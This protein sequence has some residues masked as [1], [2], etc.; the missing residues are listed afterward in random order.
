MSGI[1]NIPSL[2]VLFA[3]TFAGSLAYAG[4][5]W[6]MIVL[7]AKLG[8]PAMVGQYSFAAAI[9]YPISLIANLQ[10]RVVFVNDHEGRWP[11]RRLLGARYLLAAL[12]WVTL[13]LICLCIRSSGR[14]TAL[15]VLLGTS[16]L[17]DSLSESYY[18]LLQKSERMDRVGRSQMFKNPLCLAIAGITLYFTRDIVFAVGAALLGRLATLIFYDSA[19]ETFRITSASPWG[20][21]AYALSGTF[22]AR[23]RPQWSLRSQLEMIWIALPLGAVYVLSSFNMNI[24]RYVIE[25]YLG[26]HELGI[27]SALSYLPFAAVLFAS[28]LGYVTF[29]RLGRMFFE[30]DVPKF[31]WLL[32]RMVMIAAGLGILGFLVSAAAGK[33]ILRILYRPEYAEHVD[34]LL[35]LVVVSGV[36]CIANCMGVAMTAA[37]QFR[38]QIPLFLVM[39][40]VSALTAFALVPRIGLY[41]AALASLAAV[42]VQGVGGY[43]IVRRALKRRVAS[44]A[45]DGRDSSLVADALVSES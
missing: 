31:K 36:A 38:P 16:M 17:L 30:G 26:P 42:T 27:Y 34:L 44:A 7:F 10:L 40:A 33:P 45:K 18:S 8:N 15:I 41:G 4:A 32:G 20:A 37:S 24:P 22:F 39:G 5:Q 35:W 1:R 43:G 3:W 29:A 14:T 9:A 12:A 28:A 13:P 23:F 2:T 25:R 6:T 21:D 11:F 19:P